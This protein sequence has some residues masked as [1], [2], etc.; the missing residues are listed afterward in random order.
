MTPP[1]NIPVDVSAV[2]SSCMASSW[3]VEA[4][5]LH[6]SRAQCLTC[7]PA[8]VPE[9]PATGRCGAAADGSA[10][11]HPSLYLP[12]RHPL[13]STGHLS[14]KKNPARSL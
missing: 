10:K 8:K 3:T 7:V 13:A 14:V 6:R 9:I 12:G 11:G 5:G 1:N 2:P 4:Y